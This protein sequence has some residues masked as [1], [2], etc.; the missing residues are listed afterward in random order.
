MPIEHL[1]VSECTLTT[2]EEAAK[3]LGIDLSVLDA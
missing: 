1:D 3:T 2:N